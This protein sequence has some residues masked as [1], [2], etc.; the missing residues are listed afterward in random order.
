MFG[1]PDARWG[2]VPAA[3]VALRDGAAATPEELRQFAARRL[4]RYKVPVAV[5]VTDE[6]PRNAAGKL[7]RR[8]LQ[9]RFAGGAGES[10]GHSRGNA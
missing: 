5:Y 8:T 9:A 7:L 10:S 4:A 3:A 1:V 6:L 2:Q